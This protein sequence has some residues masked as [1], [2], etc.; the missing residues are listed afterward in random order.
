MYKKCIEDNLK[1]CPQCGFIK[2]HIVPHRN[3]YS[4]DIITQLKDCWYISYKKELMIENINYSYLI[5]RIKYVKNNNIFD[6][7]KFIYFYREAINK[8]CPE[9]L[10]IFDK[11]LLLL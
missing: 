2:V 3:L 11:I 7:N 4:N 6:Y 5:K 8:I 10:N 1:E 9:H